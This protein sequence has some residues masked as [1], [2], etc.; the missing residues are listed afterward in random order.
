MKKRR[1]IRI[2]IFIVIIGILIPANLI[3]VSICNDLLGKMKQS[4]I[5]NQQTEMNMFTNQ[6]SARLEI[7]E[8]YINTILNDNRWIGMRYAQ[9]SKEYE[10]AKNNLWL[11]IN[12]QRSMLSIF[13]SIYCYVGRASEGFSVRNTNSIS[14][15]ED[16]QILSW[17]ESGELI[18]KWKLINIG[19]QSYLIQNKSNTNFN[20]G[21]IVKKSTILKEWKKSSNRKIDIVSCGTAEERPGYYILETE[22]LNPGMELICY[23]PTKSLSQEIPFNYYMLFIS[24]L[25]GVFAIPIVF[26]LIERIVERPL[27]K[28]GS[29]IVEI[30]RG[31][32]DSRIEYFDTSKEFY[33]IEN[34]FNDLMDRIY[35][36]KIQTYEMEIENQKAQLRNLQLQI[37]PHFLLNSLN[38]V[39]GL[40]EVQSYETIQKFTLNLVK[41]LRYSLRNTNEFVALKQELDFIMN[42]VEIQKIRYP[43]RFFVVYDVED[44]LMNERIPPL[45]IENFVENSI[46]YAPKKKETEII[47]IIK[48]KEDRLH[49]SICD[50]GNGITEDVLEQIR[51]NHPV[52]DEEGEHI[53]ILNCKKRLQLFYKDMASF[54]INSVKGE[55]TQ[56]YI[57][58]P[59]QRR[60]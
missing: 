36:L 52:Q 33:A 43:N 39:Y 13:D 6:I 16:E 20:M 58:L 11:E 31:N 10:L 29:T 37:N 59:C 42:Y 50:D 41:Y 35:T 3:T 15:T 44:E 1:T 46:K 18:Q 28:M 19:E 60:Y 22:F 57:E 23:I 4:V 26:L 54:S 7:T 38:T 30:E 55:G 32:M 34:A 53:G 17:V 21:I 47:V 40:S 2:K 51:L 45:I 8:N 49:I 56:I 24:G 14:A 12:N 9:G 27:K 5:K 48:K 25:L